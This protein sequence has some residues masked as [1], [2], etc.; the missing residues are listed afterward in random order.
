[1]SLALLR[2]VLLLEAFAAAAA[3]VAGEQLIDWR[4]V[5]AAELVRSPDAANS[6]EGLLMGWGFFSGCCVGLAI[7]LGLVAIC[8]RKGIAASSAMVKG[9]WLA[10]V[11]PPIV[12]LW[13]ALGL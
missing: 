6:I 3:V 13:I 7:C 11:L 10:A 1:M 5:P 8:Q 4:N 12:I 9:H 2:V